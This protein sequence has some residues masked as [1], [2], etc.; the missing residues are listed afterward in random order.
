M[1]YNPASLKNKRK[2]R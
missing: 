2:R 1:L